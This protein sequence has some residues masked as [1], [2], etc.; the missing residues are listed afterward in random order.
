M[1]SGKEGRENEGRDS[2]RV[3]G[4]HVHTAI[5]KID[6]QQGPPEQHMKLLN[7]MWQPGQEE[8]LGENGYKNMYD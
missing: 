1:V 7:V 4:E 5:L 6:N 3:W 2:Q 8:G